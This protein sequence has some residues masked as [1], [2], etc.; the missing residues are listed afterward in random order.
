MNIITLFVLLVCIS[1]PMIFAYKIFKDL[2]KITYK[3][4]VK[5][6]EDQYI[7]PQVYCFVVAFYVGTEISNI[8]K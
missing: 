4:L 2:N 5:K 6:T 8:I 1:V 3:K 7:K